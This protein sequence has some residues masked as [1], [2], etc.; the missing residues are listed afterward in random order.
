WAQTTAQRGVPE[1][2]WFAVGSPALRARRPVWFIPLLLAGGARRGRFLNFVPRFDF[3]AG[4]P[5]A[6]HALS[7]SEGAANPPL[8]T[9]EGSPRDKQ[10]EVVSAPGP[11]IDVARA[12]G[13]YASPTRSP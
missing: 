9:P 11:S 13:L 7:L 5:L 1:T 10:E 12:G 4:T 8:T 2:W 6:G 3:S